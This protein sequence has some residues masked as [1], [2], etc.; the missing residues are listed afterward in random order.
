M[1]NP[2]MLLVSLA[3]VSL[4][5]GQ[6][7]IVPKARIAALSRG[8]RVDADTV[9][10]D[11]DQIRELGFTNVETAEDIELGFGLCPGPVER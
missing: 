3:L 5:H 4:G 1:Y 10:S 11:L 2:L 7:K 8:I 6:S 9:Q